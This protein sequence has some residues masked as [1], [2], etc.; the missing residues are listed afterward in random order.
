MFPGLI[1]LSDSPDFV[2]SSISGKKPSRAPSEPEGSAAFRLCA[3]R[4]AS[5]SFGVSV[6]RSSSVARS[7]V[8]CA[9]LVQKVEDRMGSFTD[10]PAAALTSGADVTASTTGFQRAGF[11]AEASTADDPREEKARGP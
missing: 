5:G 9:A 2:I 3:L 10:V 7:A 6:T 11:T 1:A 8:L 4:L